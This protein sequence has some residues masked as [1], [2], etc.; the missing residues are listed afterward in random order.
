MLTFAINPKLAEAQRSTHQRVKG[1]I[2]KFLS[3]KKKIH[4]Y[5]VIFFIG[6]CDIFWKVITLEKMIPSKTVE[7]M[8][9]TMT[10]A[11][12]YQS[13]FDWVIRTEGNLF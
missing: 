10:T 12:Y 3:F 7:I 11:W 6:I 4:S 8:I 2:S 1:K 13:R 9:Q 5:D